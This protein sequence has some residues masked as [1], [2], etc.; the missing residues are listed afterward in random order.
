M[1]NWERKRFLFC[2]VCLGQGR[3]GLQ[4][5][6]RT[7]CPVL[8][9]AVSLHGQFMFA[10]VHLAALCRRCTRLQP[11][12]PLYMQALNPYG[13]SKL[14]IEDMF[15]DLYAA[16]PDWRIIL[17]RYFNPVGAHPSGVRCRR[18]CTLSIFMSRC[19]VY[20]V[21][22]QSATCSASR[23]VCMVQF[24]FVPGLSFVHGPAGEIG[25]HPSGIPNNLMPYVHQVTS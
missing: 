20:E 9:T 23:W 19:N 2:N 17:L 5:D 21:L 24:T 4:G 1:Q 14:V 18:S 7:T 16:E 25:E 11:L 10:A 8:S 12:G 13:R 6:S 3:P 15:R 22:Q